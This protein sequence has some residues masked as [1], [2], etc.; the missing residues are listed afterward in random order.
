MR[1]IEGSKS[2]GESWVVEAAVVSKCHANWLVAAGSRITVVMRLSND[3]NVVG[4]RAVGISRA[5][6]NVGVTRRNSNW[7]Y[8]AARNS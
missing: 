4:A 7:L 5:G 1:R 8:C 2:E 3:C 6:S